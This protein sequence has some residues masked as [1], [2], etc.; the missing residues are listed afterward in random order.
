MG[1]GLASMLSAVRPVKEWIL[2][3]LSAGIADH[4]I[5]RALEEA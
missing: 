4:T 1:P 3:H 2:K 5:G